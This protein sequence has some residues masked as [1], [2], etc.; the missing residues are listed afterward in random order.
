MSFA[1]DALT[2]D[3]FL[4]G[5]LRLWQPRSGYRAATDPLLLAAFVPARPGERVLELGCGAGV[6]ALCL[7]ARVGGL[8][9]HGLELQPDYAALARRNAAENRLPLVVH[10]GDLRRPPDGAPRAE[11][12][13]RARQPAVPSRRARPAPPTRAATPPTARAR[14]A[15]GDWIDAGPAAADARRAAGADPPRPRG[16]AR[17]SPALEGRAGAVEIVPLAARAG[18]P[19]ERVLVRARKG[20]RAPLTLYPP[21]T[22]HEGGAHNGDGE[23]YTAAAQRVLRGMEALAPGSPRRRAAELTGHGPGR[24]GACA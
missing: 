10:E 12:R 6:A 9:L 14:P 3:A 18:R 7:A 13:P 19:A 24:E 1:D 5:R 8:E 4:D 20:S 17:S 16:S 23:S 21:F 22:L 2:C 11:L 15:L